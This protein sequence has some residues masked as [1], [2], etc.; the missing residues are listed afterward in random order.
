MS[1]R[2]LIVG[3][4]N[5]GKQYEETR[6]NVGF[7]AIHKL[8]EEYGIGAKGE[9]RFNAIVGTGHLA[10]A[11]VVLAQP[12]TFMNLSG[13]AV[14]KLLHFYKIPT[15][16]CIV[17]YD[18]AALP[19]GKIRIRPSG[20]AAGHNGIKSLIQCLGGNDQFVR[21]RIG[22]GQPDPESEK[23]MH[24]HVLSKF[25]K[26]EQTHLPA[27]LEASA[28]AAAHIMTDGVSGAMGSFNGLIVVEEIQAK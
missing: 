26:D 21:I 1:D 14:S 10:G 20:S 16:R 7:M 3:L 11:P 2:W 13:E 22:I 27:I 24:A 9:T 12:T 5:P 4:G 15:E 25:T 18:E 17:I 23:P 6:H 19:F 8:S 28:K